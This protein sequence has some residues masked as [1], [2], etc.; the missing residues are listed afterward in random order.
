MNVNDPAATPTPEGPPRHSF[1]KRPEGACSGGRM[2]KAVKKIPLSGQIIIGMI[3]GA[4]VGALVGPK[5]APLGEL[6]KLVIQLIKTVAAPLLYLAIVNA[7]VKT[8][9]SLAIGARMGVVATTNATI[10][11]IFGLGLSNLIEPGKYLKMPDLSALPSGLAS[12]GVMTGQKIDLLKTV[13][14]YIPSNFVGPFAE[15]MI[16]SIVLLALLVGF[17]LRSVKRRQLGRQETSYRALEDATT[18]LYEV[19]EITLGWIV[20]LAPVAV[21]GVVAKAVGQYGFSPFKGLGIYVGVGLFGL[22][23]HMLITYQLWIALYAKMSLRKFWRQAKEAMVYSFGANS[24]LATLPLTLKALDGMGVSRA[25]STLG[26]C[27]GT[28]LNNDGIILYEAMAVLFVA[29][30]HGLDLSLAQQLIA[31]LFCLV[32]AMG[33]A[34][35]PEAGFISLS[36]VLASVGLPQELLPLLLTVDWILAR[37]RSVVNVA[38]DMVVSIILDRW[39][40]RASG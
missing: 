13:G 11:L 40:A 33:V 12:P 3:L 26:A 10:A 18:A 37:A 14:A 32:A 2:N 29:Q 19:M 21:F 24:S 8:D 15:N 31:A 5:A 34:G 6:G 22:T 17:G 39:G 35:V 7:I 30:A 23:L 25:A 1:F 20:R 27:V 16:I 36:L 38:S 9:V 4:A 28:N